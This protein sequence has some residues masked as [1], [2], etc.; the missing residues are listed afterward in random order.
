M[1]KFVY[2]VLFLILVLEFLLIVR[3][4]IIS[5]LLRTHKDQEDSKN[6]D[7]GMVFIGDSYASVKYLD[8]AYADFFDYAGVSVFDYSKGNTEWAYI[9]SVLS[10]IDSAENVDLVLFIQFGDFVDF[11]KTGAKASYENLIIQSRTFNLL[12]DLGHHAS[13]LLFKTPLYG[14]SFYSFLYNDYIIYHEMIEAKILNISRR[15]RRVYIL[16]NYPMFAPSKVINTSPA[17]HFF[18]NL[19]NQDAIDHIVQ[20]HDIIDGG[21]ACS[22]SW[23]NGHPNQQTVRQISAKLLKLMKGTT[24]TAPEE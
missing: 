12:K 24:T 8:T 13:F 6:I 2:H 9:D 17:Y 5:N 4:S 21:V 18:E 11:R 16:V 23:R 3:E 7:R 20:S 10:R 1:R 14:S 19:K 22:V 15:F